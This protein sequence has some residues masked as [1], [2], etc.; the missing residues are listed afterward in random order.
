MAWPFVGDQHQSLFFPTVD[1]HMR[2][3]ALPVRDTSNKVYMTSPQQLLL[4]SDL[5]Y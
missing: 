2:G 1:D 4:E 3:Q 5:K